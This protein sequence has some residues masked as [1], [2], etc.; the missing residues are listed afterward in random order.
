MRVIGLLDQ[1]VERPQDRLER[2]GLGESLTCR[3]TLLGE[4]G[5]ETVNK[6][7]LN[8]HYGP[9]PQAASSARRAGISFAIRR[10]SPQMPQIILLR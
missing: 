8:A 1:L 3:V 9:F 4:H 2:R 7:R 6:G 5:A 10:P